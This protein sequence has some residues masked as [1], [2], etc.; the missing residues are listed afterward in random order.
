[1]SALVSVV[2]PVYNLEEY[3]ENCINSV[4][5]QTYENIEIICVDDG[6]TDNS[7]DVVRDVAK[8][9][10][11]VRYIYQENSGVSA[12]RNT[13]MAEAQ[14]EY[15]MFIDGDDYIH[16]QSIDI[17]L[18]CIEK[19]KVDMVS[20]HQQ[21]TFELDEEMLPISEYECR[22][23]AH[24]DLFQTVNGNVIGKSSCAKLFRTD[25][26][27]KVS[28]PVGI[29]N[30]EDAN[31]IIKLLAGGMK[32]AIVDKVLYYYYTREDSC[33][34]SGF[35]KNK[36]SITLSFDDLCEYLKNT[37]HSFLKAYC[38]QYLFQSI[39]YNR[40]LSVGTDAQKYV[41]KESKRIG[42]KWL[43]DFENNND[44]D[45]NIRKLFKIFFRSRA[46]YELA[47]MAKDPTM[48]I[49]YLKRPFQNFKRKD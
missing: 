38:L 28:F 5:A 3:I 47:R 11:R 41:L 13:G 22:I 6:S 20:A 31:F 8:N 1:M 14:G 7:A 15:L 37:E 9:D 36:F 49:F 42:E 40:T 44:I 35:S 45:Q 39:F 21:C 24:N 10:T 4:T 26:A 12:A 19:Y 48:L 18:D 32:T 27:R 34:T 16:P 46:V 30:G 33:V 23:S 43:S 29:S 17:L 2:I 25:I